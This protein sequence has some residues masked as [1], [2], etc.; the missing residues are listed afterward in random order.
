MPEV[1]ILDT[2]LWLW[3]VNANFEQFPSGWR[4]EIESVARVGVSPISCYEIALAHQ[5]GRI[6]LPSTP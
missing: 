5:K 2:H 3:L 1:I 4:D 6:Q